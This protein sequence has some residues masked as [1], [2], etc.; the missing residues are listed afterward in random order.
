MKAGAEES[1]A[2]SA[3]APPLPMKESALGGPYAPE[4]VTLPPG[5]GAGGLSQARG[6]GRLLMLDKSAAI[7]YNQNN[8]DGWGGLWGLRS[9]WQAWA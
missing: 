5:S 6:S 4:R 7:L 2:S 9:M 8:F 3:E 1:R